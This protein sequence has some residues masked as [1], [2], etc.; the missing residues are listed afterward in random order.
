MAKIKGGI[1][2]I[3]MLGG[4]F[5]ELRSKSQGSV[6]SHCGSPSAQGTRRRRKNCSPGTTKSCRVRVDPVSTGWS[7]T[8][9]Q[10]SG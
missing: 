8:G 1:L 4:A 6:R 2:W 10:E 9:C 5:D 7:G 3:F